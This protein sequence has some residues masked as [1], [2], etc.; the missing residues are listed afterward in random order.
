MMCEN[1]NLW[2]DF[3][4]NLVTE[5]FMILNLKCHLQRRE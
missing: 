3:P 4:V 1:C 2:N 5:M